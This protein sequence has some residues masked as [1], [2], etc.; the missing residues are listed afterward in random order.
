MNRKLVLARVAVADEFLRAHI[1]VLLGAPDAFLER[2]RCRLVQDLHTA[3][4]AFGDV[5]LIQSWVFVAAAGRDNPSLSRRQRI[6]ANAVLAVQ[7]GR[8]HELLDSVITH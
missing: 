6:A 5:H 1:E 7:L 3:A 2:R 4:W 8:G